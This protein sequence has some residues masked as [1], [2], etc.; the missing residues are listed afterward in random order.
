[1]Q[2]EYEFYLTVHSVVPSLNFTEI[3]HSHFMVSNILW[4][5]SQESGSASL[6]LLRC[7]SL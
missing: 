2:K 6:H 5:H 7:L 3:A 4:V 1:M